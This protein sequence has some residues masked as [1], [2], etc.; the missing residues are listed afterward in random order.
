MWLFALAAE[1]AVPLLCGLACLW[2]V[3]RLVVYA[4]LRRFG[5]PLWAGL[6]DWPHSLAM[7]RHRN[8][9]W[10]AE[11]NEKYGPIARVAPRVLVT[12][13]PDVWIH[14]NTK[15]GY[16]RSDWYYHACRLEHRR[17]NIFS[18]TDNRKH[19]VRRKQM[20]PG[21]SGRENLELE[22]TIDQRLAELLALIRTHYLPATAQ[23]A[24]QPMDLG[25]K[26]QFFTLDVISSVGLGRSFGMLPRNADVD[27]HVRL[28]EQGL[29]AA[30]AALATGLSRLAHV[31][32]IGRFVA[33]SPEDSGGYGRVMAACFR[34]VDERVGAKGPSAAAAAAH[35]HED[36]LASFM[37]HGIEGHDLRSEALEQV[38]AGSDTTAG[39]LRGALLHIMSN[40]RVHAKLQ[41][42]VDAEAAATGSDGIVEAARARQLPYLQ[43][44]VRE[45]LRI[46]PPAVNIFARDVPAGGDTVVVD[47]RP[48][49]LPAGVSI[50]YSALAMH[51][52]RDVYGPDAHVFRPERWFEPDPDRLA[53]M[54]RTNEL[55]FGHA[56]FRCLGRPVAMIEIS[57]T[58]FELMRNFE[59]AL[60]HP[61]R[62]WKTRNCLGLFMISDMWVQVMDRV[63]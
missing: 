44:V 38:V 63:S 61:T 50:G 39:A 3:R 60:I 8:H 18:Q 16:K 48:V 28:S 13:S 1:H 41:R 34:A 58:I 37:R 43:A 30:N 2:L 11:V 17:D 26:V 7:L 20:A 53:A 4:R 45:S 47:G 22:H 25:E 32:G 24:T 36:M 27:G 59:M 51:R 62:P 6:S 46:W 57:K 35:R 55:V 12:S 52:S 42:E 21:Y 19:D 31:P 23:A 49:F 40:A 54:V 14:V 33:P 5:G 9:E 15:P 29:V 56:R 10:Y